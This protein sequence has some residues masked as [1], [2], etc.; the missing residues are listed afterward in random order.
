MNNYPIWD[1]RS[2]ISI[3]PIPVEFAIQSLSRENLIEILRSYQYLLKTNQMNEE[4]FFIFSNGIR[5]GI[6]KYQYPLITLNLFYDY[7]EF[8]SSI[9]EGLK[10]LEKNHPNVNYG[11]THHLYDEDISIDH[12][13]LLLNNFKN[14]YLNYFGRPRN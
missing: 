2:L 7:P 1:F 9:I 10:F 12:I 8:Y 3:K 11:N 5:K 14:L 13:C 6:S 4:L